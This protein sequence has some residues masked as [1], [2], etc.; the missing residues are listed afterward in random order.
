MNQ[1]LTSHMFTKSTLEYPP[2]A[3]S[4][5][6]DDSWDAVASELHR[7]R[8][9]EKEMAL[10]WSGVGPILSEMLKSS[11]NLV[12][13]WP[14]FVLPG[15]GLLPT[16][17]VYSFAR[18]TQIDH[19]NSFGAIAHHL[20]K[21]FLNHKMTEMRQHITHLT[22]HNM[23]IFVECFGFFRDN[24]ARIQAN[25]TLVND[26]IVLPEWS[27]FLDSQGYFDYP[28]FSGFFPDRQCFETCFRD[29]FH[30]HHLLYPYYGLSLV[31]IF[32]GQFDV[33]NE[34][35]NHDLQPFDVFYLRQILPKLLKSA[36]DC[37]VNFEARDAWIR[38]VQNIINSLTG[39][40]FDNRCGSSVRTLVNEHNDLIKISEISWVGADGMAPDI[41]SP[42]LVRL[43]ETEH[44]YPDNIP[45]Y[46]G[47]M[48][49]AAPPSDGEESDEDDEIVMP[50]KNA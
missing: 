27:Q 32:S 7:L 22:K 23:P 37:S 39:D 2:H 28:K 9:A 40:F 10:F 34:I 33:L 45:R 3:R 47:V 19:P 17:Q 14:A 8:L 50:P 29:V 11:N 21:Y 41:A 31:L 35:M 44:P 15:V 36:I 13:P 49:P 16:K 6:Q 12:L 1:C 24:W 43:Y 42:C 30:S 46:L 25:Y 48:P 26:T 38:H 5:L 4:T 20:V 18:R